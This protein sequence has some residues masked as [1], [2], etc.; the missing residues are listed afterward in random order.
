MWLEYKGLIISKMLI[1]TPLK[2]I[3]VIFRI[4]LI[5]KKIRSRMSIRLSSRGSKS[6]LR[7]GR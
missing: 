3:G 7:Q 2:K 1:I 4:L 5:F 6:L